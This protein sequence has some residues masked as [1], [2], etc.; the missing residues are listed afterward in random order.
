MG[1][2]LL[3]VVGMGGIAVFVVVV[4][5]GGVFNR[6]WRCGVIYRRVPCTLTS[7]PVS[8]I[9]RGSTVRLPWIYRACIRWKQLSNTLS[10][11][12]S[13]SMLKITLRYTL[14]HDRQM[15]VRQGE[16]QHRHTADMNCNSRVHRVRALVWLRRENRRREYRVGRTVGQP[17]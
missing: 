17:L 2:A 15:V 5:V 3:T 13:S 8:G 11:A 12:R 6:A 4:P 9:Y 16:A 7:S 14:S 1:F 10:L